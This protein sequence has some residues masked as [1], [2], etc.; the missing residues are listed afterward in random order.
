[1]LNLLFRFMIILPLFQTWLVW[2]GVTIAQY[3]EHGIYIAFATILMIYILLKKPQFH[4]NVLILFFIFFA[5]LVAGFLTSLIQEMSHNYL[6]INGIVYEVYKLT[7]N[8]SIFIFAYFLQTKND[9]LKNIRLY[10]FTTFILVIVSLFEYFGGIKAYTFMHFLPD[11]ETYQDFYYVYL[12][13]NR[14]M[15]LMKHPSI[16]SSFVFVSLMI[17]IYAS[18]IKYKILK[19]KSLQYLLL[20]ISLVGIFISSTRSIFILSLLIPIA[21][22]FVFNVKKI[23]KI[24]FVL[25]IFSMPFLIFAIKQL[26]FK[27]WQYKYYTIEQGQTEARIVWW[28]EAISILKNNYLFGSGLGTWG[29]ASATFSSFMPNGRVVPMSD[30]YLSHLITE[31]GINLIFIIFIFIFSFIFFYKGFKYHSDK[32]YKV[33]N[34]VGIS[35]LLCTF[36]ESFKSMQLSMYENTF[37]MFYIFGYLFKVNN[38]KIDLRQEPQ[39]DIIKKGMPLKS[40]KRYKL[41]WK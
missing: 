32:F 4:K 33:L 11:P 13:D 17:L 22:S 34:L 6:S 15:G 19:H 31:N 27:L 37:F 10:F 28:K 2:N 26:L 8:I 25:V 39:E 7:R 38:M 20:L 40:R 36:F 24:Y 14:T 41:V 30:S 23:R 35:L 1:V 9:V 16:Y 21:L 29:D 3:I 5:F 12:R 18:A